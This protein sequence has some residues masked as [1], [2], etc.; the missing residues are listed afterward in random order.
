MLLDPFKQRTLINSLK[1]ECK[2]Y[3]DKALANQK[4]VKNKIKE[5]I[6]NHGYIKTAPSNYIIL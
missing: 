2:K 6:K 5:L 4:K 3:S 1:S